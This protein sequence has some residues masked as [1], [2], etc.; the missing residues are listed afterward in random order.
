M[1]SW[2]VWGEWTSEFKYFHFAI[3]AFLLRD[4]SGYQNRLIF[5]K[6]PKGG[7]GHFQSKNLYWRF[8]TFIKGFFR[9]FS[10]KNCNIIF[11]KW[12]GRFKRRLEFFQQI[13]RFGSLTRPYAFVPELILGRGSNNQNGNLKWHLPWQGGV[14]V[15]DTNPYQRYFWIFCLRQLQPARTATVAR[16]QQRTW[17]RSTS[18]L[19]HWTN[20][21]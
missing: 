1:A 11:G 6:L 12:G 18:S 3:L 16:I 10:E 2:E 14:P 5:G 15:L 17:S 7:G 13:I 8:L 21:L 19:A 4:G 20:I 9:T